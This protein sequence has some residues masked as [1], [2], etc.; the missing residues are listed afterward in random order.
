[1]IMGEGAKGAVEKAYFPRNPVMPL[2][3]N[4]NQT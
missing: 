2:Y 1:M 4:V 3:E